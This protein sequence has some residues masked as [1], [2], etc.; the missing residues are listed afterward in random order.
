MKNYIFLASLEKYEELMIIPYSCL[1]VLKVGAL[2]LGANLS[3]LRENLGIVHSLPIV[4]SCWEWGLWSV[5]QPFSIHS[6][7][8]FS[9]SL[10]L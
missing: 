3:L 8:T 4:C 9:H 6:D 7:V 2:H 5:Y 10:D 1:E